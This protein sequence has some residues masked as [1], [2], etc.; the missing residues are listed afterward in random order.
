ML[1][2]FVETVDGF[3]FRHGGKG[4]VEEWRG[5]GLYSVADSGS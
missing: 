2:A 4:L 5:K 1:E 3:W